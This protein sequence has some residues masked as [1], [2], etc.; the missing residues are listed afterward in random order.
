MNDVITNLTKNKRVCIVAYND[1]L[2]QLE[3][4]KQIDSYDTVIRMNNHH[5]GT[6]QLQYGSKRTIEVHNFMTMPQIA[7]DT[8]LV[9]TA[10]PLHIKG[11]PWTTHFKTSKENTGICHIE[12]DEKLFRIMSNVLKAFPS[13]GCITLMTMFPYIKDMTCFHIYGMDS[14]TSVAYLN[15]NGKLIKREEWKDHHNM[16][17][18]HEFLK[19]HFY[20]KNKDKVFIFNS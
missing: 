16:Y 15:V 10:H 8:Q 5:F 14:Y 3:Y 6:K 11:E 1:H 2:D 20:N 9:L 17:S 18:E 12:S 4:G 19:D 7:N 13:T